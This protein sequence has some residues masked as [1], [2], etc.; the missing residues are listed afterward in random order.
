MNARALVKFAKEHLKSFAAWAGG[1]LATLIYNLVTGKAVW[2]QTAAQWWQYV[3]TGF[4]TAIVVWLAP[5]NKITQK[6]L[7][8]DP[9]VMGGVVVPDPQPSVVTAQA[10]QGQWTSP[11]RPHI[12]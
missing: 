3:L 9:H 4:G 12:G 6:Q 5:A 2:P 8:K 1:V 11:W 10:P 7:D